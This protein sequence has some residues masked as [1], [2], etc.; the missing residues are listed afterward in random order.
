MQVKWE[1]LIGKWNTNES[2]CKEVEKDN[3]SEMHKTNCLTAKSCKKIE[4]SF[5]ALKC[6]SFP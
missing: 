2:K 3:G 4:T 6:M 5:E 1:L